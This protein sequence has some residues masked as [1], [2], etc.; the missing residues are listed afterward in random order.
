MRITVKML[1][2]VSKT[3]TFLF[4]SPPEAEM[5]VGPLGEPTIVPSMMDDFLG[6]PSELRR[7]Q[8]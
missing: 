6:I 2:F 7:G 1:G 5:L 4:T 8:P 3:L